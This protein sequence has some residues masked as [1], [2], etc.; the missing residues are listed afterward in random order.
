MKN[1]QFDVLVKLMR[2]NPESA[3][4][5][6][7]RRVLVDRWTQADAHHETQATR[8]TVSDAVKK[9]TEAFDMVSEAWAPKKRAPKS[10]PAVTE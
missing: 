7:A 8:Q 5:K 1:E 2:G 4:N 3:A 9:Y 6:A 10:A